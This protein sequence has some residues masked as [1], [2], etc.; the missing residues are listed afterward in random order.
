MIR[1]IQ[2]IILLAAMALGTTS[3]LEK[4]PENAIPTNKA[5]KTVSDINQA[6][7]G[8]YAGFKS[9]ALYSGA[10]TLC[11]DIQADLVYGVEGNTNQYG[12]FWR[13]EVL[14]DSKE[15]VGVY[16][17]L[18]SIISLCNFV[19]ENVDPVR[20]NTV[21]D[22]QLNT[23]DE[24]VGEIYFARALAYSKLIELFC[25]AYDPQTAAQTLGVVLR[26]RYSYPEPLR[27]ASLEASYK[28]VL[29]DLEQAEKLIVL[30]NQPNGAVVDFFSIN[31]V[32]SLYARIYL[33][34]H[35]WDKAIDYST[36][37]IKDPA[38]KLASTMEQAT[39]TKSWYR[40]MWTNDTSGEVIWRINFSQTS[41]GGAI[42]RVFLNYDYT[43]FKPDYV[44]AL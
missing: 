16:G 7:L 42:G 39:S 30:E 10:M 20:A 43:S 26:S 23:L 22:E 2:L 6:V 37:V 14:A 29:A 40:Y 28:F 21:D 38:M 13:W 24:L 3:C 44:P 15:V 11:P 5:L 32:N 4:Y 1:K 31:S 19:L 34:M 12:D 35:E 33:Y 8:I 17:G 25:K 41:Y 18:Y 9:P 36:K 27:R